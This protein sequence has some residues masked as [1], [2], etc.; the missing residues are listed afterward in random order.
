MPRF[1]QRFL[2]L[3]VILTTPLFILSLS[4]R[5]SGFGVD[6]FKK[7]LVETKTYEMAS[8]KIALMI[9][10]AVA[11]T[12]RK[13]PLRKV[14]EEF[15]G[16]LTPSY[17]EG[18]AVAVIDSTIAWFTD[19]RLPAPTLSFADLKEPLLAKNP[20]LVDQLLRFQ[21]EYE[22]NLPA[23][24]EALIE[25]AATDPTA[26]VPTLPEINIQRFIDNDMTVPVAQ[27]VS[28]LKPFY[29]FFTYGLQIT[30]LIILS[31]LALLF[32]ALPKP[33]NSK[34]VARAL[35]LSAFF[36]GLPLTL[37]LPFVASRFPTLPTISLPPTFIQSYNALSAIAMD[38]Y[39]RSALIV[40]VGF[41]AVG[42]VLL[43]TAKKSV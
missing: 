15:K 25:Q 8:T 17:I 41:L 35:I 29:L 31:C 9:D 43:K 39:V 4:V 7:T 32:V 14:A 38:A 20:G 16:F 34:K 36:S 3:I 19:S 24:Q 30:S 13:D 1:I 2:T 6:T 5:L 18:K 37:Q 40:V 21:L 33:D 23:M 27:Y 22:K 12:P 11:D 10:E 26:S 42:A 28:F